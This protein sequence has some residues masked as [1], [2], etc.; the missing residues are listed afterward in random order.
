MLAVGTFV[1][2]TVPLV[3]DDKLPLK[4]VE[5][6]FALDVPLIEIDAPFTDVACPVRTDGSM[7]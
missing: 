6:W 3:F 1:L 5:V 7:F 2:V 4:T